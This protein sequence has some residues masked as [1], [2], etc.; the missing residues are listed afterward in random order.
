LAYALNSL[1]CGLIEEKPLRQIIWEPLI[2]IA[3]TWSAA[4]WIL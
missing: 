4:F 2:T 1:I 3:V